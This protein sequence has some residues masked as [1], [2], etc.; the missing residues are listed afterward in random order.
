MF[1]IEKCKN[2]RDILIYIKDQQ[3][4]VSVIVKSSGKIDIL[5]NNDQTDGSS[6]RIY[7]VG[8]DFFFICQTIPPYSRSVS[9]D[10]T[11]TRKQIYAISSI[12]VL[13]GFFD[14]E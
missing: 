5:R 4:N 13:S 10:I 12:Q 6:G 7:Q 9:R 2:I 11:T 3:L 8:E 1:E 14:S